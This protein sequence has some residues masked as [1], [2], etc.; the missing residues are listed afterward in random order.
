MLALAELGGMFYLFPV[1]LPITKGNVVRTFCVGLVALVA[2][3][4]FVTNL[5]APFTMAAKDVYAATG[6][7]A[8]LIPEGFQGGALD[9]AS[10]LMSWTI[11]HLTHSLGLIG[12]SG[13][14]VG[15]AGGLDKKEILLNIERTH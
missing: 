9:F 8:V 6:D 10:S 14:L 12:S 5:A 15:F 11:Y 7:S 13:K 3:L 2:G 1:V 4:Y